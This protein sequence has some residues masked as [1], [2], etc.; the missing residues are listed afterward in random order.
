MRRRLATICAAIAVTVLSAALVAALPAMA[1]ASFARPTLP[2]IEPQVMCVTCKIPLNTA[3]S[4]QASA[5]RTFIREQISAGKDEAQVKDA[6]VAQYGQ[7]VLA[8]PSTNGFGIA[9]YLVPIA[10]V[11]VLIAVLALL[12][13]RWRRTARAD[14]RPAGAT[15]LSDADAERLQ[16]DMRRFE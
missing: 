1:S 8:L 9:A 16:E 14:R 2:G 6:L 11:I 10:V 12:L 7:A 13:P 4:P 5:E 3:E 15:A